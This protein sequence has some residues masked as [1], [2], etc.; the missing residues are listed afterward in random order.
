MKKALIIIIILSFSISCSNT[1]KKTILPESTKCSKTS[2]F[3]NIDICLPEIQ[4]MSECYSNPN[5][6]PVVDNLV[7]KNNSIVGF[8]LNDNQ[9]ENINNIKDNFFFIFTSNDLK[10]KKIEKND[11]I[12]YYENM[13]NLSRKIDLNSDIK[14]MLEDKKL[15]TTT[16]DSP[17]LI[18][19]YSSN[20]ETRTLVTMVYIKN[21]KYNQEAISLTILNILNIKDRIVFLSF[22]TDSYNGEKSIIDAKAKNDYVVLK[23][24]E[25]NK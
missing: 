25:I 18:E 16:I 24:L 10:N 14:S 1:N 5:I 11:F 21:T 7:L 13:E 20:K 23:L 19:S 12:S 9:C 2:P 6:K 4:G 15:F 17:I 8:Y 22:N 3:G